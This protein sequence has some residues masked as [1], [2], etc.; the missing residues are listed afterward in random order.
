MIIRELQ[1]DD[2][3]NGFLESLDS[4]RAAS[5][6]SRELA[7]QIFTDISANKNH[8]IA[9]AELDGK[10]VAATTL[11]IEQKFI[12]NGG[13]TGHIEDVVVHKDHQ[14]KKIGREIVQYLLNKA[15]S[16]GCYKT[17]LDCRDELRPFYEKIGFIEH[18]FQMRFD[19]N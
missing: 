8:I 7:D 2:L 12:H 10:I 3:W 4:L 6:I 18:G 17:V 1:R 16:M 9:V 15:A 13:K 5:N 19:H 11:I 14:G